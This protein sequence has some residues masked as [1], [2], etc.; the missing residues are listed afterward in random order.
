MS[1][2][3]PGSYLLHDAMQ[4]CLWY[5]VVGLAVAAHTAHAKEDS[6]VPKKHALKIELVS[7]DTEWQPSYRLD[8]DVALFY[9]VDPVPAGLGF[10]SK[11]R[12][13]LVDEPKKEDQWSINLQ[14]QIPSGTDCTRM[15][16]LVCFDSQD[17]QTVVKPLR[18]SFWVIWRKA[19]HF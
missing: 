11:A 4:I 18:D 8:S 16:S 6:F 13:F 2:L 15:S 1:G 14:R 12:P 7:A 17:Q 9:P 19:L 5:V 10:I 3:I